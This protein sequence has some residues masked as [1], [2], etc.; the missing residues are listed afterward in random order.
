MP[1]AATLL[2]IAHVEGSLANALS[3]KLIQVAARIDKQ[4]RSDL[5]PVQDLCLHVE[6]YRGKMMRPTLTMLAGLAVTGRDD[7][8]ALSANHVMIGAVVELIHLATLVHDDVLDEADT[9]RRGATIN[10][11]RGNE[12]AV[13]LGDYLISKAFHLC[14]HID[15]QQVALRIGA[16]TNRVCEGELLQLHHRNNFSLDEPTYYEII[17]RKTASLIGVACELGAE[18]AGASGELSSRFRE[19]GVK[20]GVAFQIRDDL[21]DITGAES[22][23]GKSL[24]KDLEKGKLT[25]PLIHHLSTATASQR[26]RTLI[27]LEGACA[28]EPTRD[29][30]IRAAL[31]ET[32]SIQYAENQSERLAGEARHAIDDLPESAARDLLFRLAHLVLTRQH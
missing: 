16:I 27:E 5:P 25:L 3:S 18:C 14:S 7:A 13:I 29:G 6:R 32:G 19:Y 4:V 17:E 28:G 11:L 1:A 10:S 30:S 24:G 21:L 9:R 22:V 12:I 15:N 23:V 20:L 26:G 2:E 31:E 8:E